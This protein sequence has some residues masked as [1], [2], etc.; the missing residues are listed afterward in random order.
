MGSKKIVAEM[1]K[2]YQYRDGS[3]YT[4]DANVV[5]DELNRIYEKNG[6]VRPVD[7]VSEA[8]PKSAPLH[9]VFEWRDSIAADQYRNWQARR[10]IKSV[11]TVTE[12]TTSLVPVSVTTRSPEYTHLQ[13]NDESERGYHPTEVVVSRPDMYAVALSELVRKFNAAKESVESLKRAAEQSPE[14]DQERMS[15]IAI[16][17][18]AM[19]TASA[20]VAAL[21]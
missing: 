13:H 16:A 11:I 18:Q 6:V 21:H 4:I 20:A 15:R 10:L 19:Q 1:R 17:V 2:R 5:G 9:P 7:V 14:T 3:R 8:R 12:D